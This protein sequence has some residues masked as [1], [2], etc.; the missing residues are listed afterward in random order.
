MTREEKKKVHEFEKAIGY[1]FKK[2]AMLARALTHRS[3][4]N[5]HKLN[6]DQQNERLEFL[7]DAVL[8]LA[9]SELLMERFPH[10]SEGDL[11]KMRAAIVNEKQLASLARS[12]RLGEY[13]YLGRGEDQTSGR[14]KNSL[15]ADAYE[16]V[17]G[18]IY[19]DRGFKKAAAVI[20]AHYSRLLNNTEIASLYKDYKTDLQEKCQSLFRVTPRYKLV[21]EMGPDHDKVFDIEIYVNH[22]LMGRGKGHSKKEAEQEAAK[23]ALEKLCSSQATSPS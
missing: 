16:A 23:G 3:F 19:M 8:E 21:A 13:L 4:A 10:F 2:K 7:G 20:K 11:S 15:L 6:S 1:S 9:V 14:E 17:L 18:G 22:E 12:F 5:E